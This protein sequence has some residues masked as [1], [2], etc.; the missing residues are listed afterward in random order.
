MECE[1]DDELMCETEK[2]K[3]HETESNGINK[4]IAQDSANHN[5]DN[6]QGESTDNK[7]D[8]VQSMEKSHYFPEC[9]DIKKDEMRPQSS[10][11]VKD[12][13]QQQVEQ[14][15]ESNLMKSGL[16]SKDKKKTT[17]IGEFAQSKRGISE[18]QENGDRLSNDES[19]CSLDTDSS[20]R[21][22]TDENVNGSLAAS[23]RN[24]LPTQFH[25]LKSKVRKRNYRVKQN[26]Q[27]EA[28]DSSDDV[29]TGESTGEET[30]TVDG[31]VAQSNHHLPSTADEESNLS[32]NLD[33]AEDTSD[34]LEENSE[35]EEDDRTG[36][37]NSNEWTSASESMSSNEPVHPVMSKEKPKPQWFIVPE[38]INRQLGCNRLFQSR[39]YGSLHTVQRLELMYKLKEHK[40]C[41]NTLSFNQRGNYLASGSDDLMV[42]IW[43]W[44]LGKKHHMFKTGH[45][46]NVFQASWLPLPSEH[47][48]VTCARDGHVRLTDLH[49]SLVDCSRRLAAHQG[50]ATKLS[51]HPEIPHVILSVGED[52]KVFAIDIRQHKPTT[53]LTLK[54]GQSQVAIYSINSNPFNSNEFCLGGRDQYVRLYDKRKVST[55]L[56]KLCPKHLKNN[57]SHAHVTSVKYNYNGS[58]IVASYNDEDIYLFDTLFPFSIGDF[59]HRYQGHRNNATVKGVNFFGPKSEFVISG[60][61]CGNIFIWEKNT[62]AIVQWMTGDENGVVNRLEPHPHI[63]VLATSGLDYDVKVWVPSCEKPPVMKDL[64]TCI[65][66]NMRSRERNMS[67]D[68]DAFDG[69]LLWFLWRHVRER[70]ERRVRARGSGR[71]SGDAQ[72]REDAGTSSDDTSR[73]SNSASEDEIDTRPQCSPS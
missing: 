27:D 73:H 69:Q 29:L 25:K 44:P 18:G 70:E 10:K 5:E 41:V 32:A 17:S 2:S 68:P 50:P 54:E 35:G 22:K 72:G 64:E 51:I 31:D 62:E 52:A 65:K 66:Y 21:Q 6:A 43:D 12:V 34:E 1:D 36:N 39:F 37:D 71:G 56:Y 14:S 38:V 63:P 40:G 4:V 49:K 59:A 45:T 47:L 53:L 19:K 42:V 13:S 26:I 30:E 20:K 15:E 28:Q 58:E 61:D 8:R 60:S 33:I 55:P 67:R 24:E 23:C 7:D 11:M 48:M 3:S 16:E 9:S 46:S 57:K